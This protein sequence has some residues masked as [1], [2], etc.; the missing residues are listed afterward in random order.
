MAEHFIQGSNTAIALGQMTE[1]M[2]H[3]MKECLRHTFMGSKKVLEVIRQLYGAN[4]SQAEDVAGL[5]L[6]AKSVQKRHTALIAKR[7]TYFKYCLELLK[8]FIAAMRHQKAKDIQEELAELRRRAPTDQEA[9]ARAPATALSA[10]PPTVIVPAVV[11]AVVAAETAV[12]KAT[13]AAAAA[14]TTLPKDP[15]AIE[16]TAKAVERA[17]E[18]LTE[19]LADK[20]K[21]RTKIRRATTSNRY[22]QKLRDELNAALDKTGDRH[23]QDWNIWRLDDSCSNKSPYLSVDRITE[24]T[25]D[26][27]LVQLR[28]LAAA[29]LDTVQP[30]IDAT[31]GLKF[32]FE[33]SS[34]PQLAHSGADSRSLHGI[35]RCALNKPRRPAPPPSAYVDPDTESDADEGLEETETDQ[36]YGRRY[37]RTVSSHRRGDRRDRVR[38]LQE[39]RSEFE[40][41]HEA[42]P[43]SILFYP[44]VTL[45]AKADVG[46]DAWE[47]TRTALFFYDTEDEQGEYSLG[48]VRETVME[49]LEGEVVRTEYPVLELEEVTL[50][51]GVKKGICEADKYKK[52]TSITRLIP[53]TDVIYS[54]AATWRQA[55]SRSSP[56]G[57]YVIEADAQHEALAQV[58]EHAQWLRAREY[59]R[60]AAHEQA[61]VQSGE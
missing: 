44:S 11:T 21:L 33:R 55:E 6:K 16:R 14:A 40:T 18:K 49:E 13:E 54:C 48:I 59:R 12:T 51:R 24:D 50:R 56:E 41:V 1:S 19:K 25:S 52:M 32:L 42:D 27:K 4:L 47:N 43:E 28:Q 58:D 26:A 37:N 31:E 20:A 5:D 39:E 60:E 45:V 61:S 38:Q 3:E 10:V 35:N 29:E 7:Q 17:D 2:M 46:W 34:L 22:K 9:W 53:A 15:T 30:L 36:T 57:H 23:I 8:K